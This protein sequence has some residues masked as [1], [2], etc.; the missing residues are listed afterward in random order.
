MFAWLRVGS[1][2][3]PRRPPSLGVAEGATD[4]PSLVT[5]GVVAPPFPVGV[6]SAAATS[7]FAAFA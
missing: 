4:E 3:L 5:P 2:E 6:L 1:L 7:S